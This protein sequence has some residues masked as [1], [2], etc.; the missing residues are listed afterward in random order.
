MM[1]RP[2]TPAA[3]PRQPVSAFAGLDVCETAGLRLAPGT[4]R[5]L[6]DQDR[7]VLSALLDAHRMV[8]D[9]ELIWEFTEIL[10]PRWRTVAKEILLALLA[11]QNE[12]V[13][14]CAHAIRSVRSPRTCFRFLQQFT[15]WFNWL[16][17]QG[18]T[19]LDE[20]TQHLCERYLE[21]RHWSVP[22][23]GEQRRRLEPDTMA[24]VARTVQLPV[25]YGELLSSDAYPEGFAPW[26]GRS[27]SAVVGAKMGGPNRVPPVPDLV[28]QPLLATCLYLVDVV[29]PHVADLL[30]E[31]RADA[32][33]GEDLPRV[34]R[35]VCPRYARSSQR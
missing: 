16:T 34:T 33:V 10:N 27:A 20:V 22:T 17:K 25:L 5:V 31:V 14:Q 13:L 28:L 2:P 19:R 1:P 30:D 3:R 32:G 12:A 4:A 24:E 29:G 8:K 26:E 23:P 15:D 18:I 35:S 11:P 7:W 9:H 21:E 6:F